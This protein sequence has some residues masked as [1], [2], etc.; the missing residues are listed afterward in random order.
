M[1]GQHYVAFIARGIESGLVER[2]AQVQL[3]FYAGSTQQKL[4]A[5]FWT[6][7]QPPLYHELR[8]MSQRDFDW[9]VDEGYLEPVED[10]IYTFNTEA[11]ITAGGEP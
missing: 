6:G 8:Q 11:F 10:N 4:V 2:Y 9:L 1:S 5:R 3:G 7:V